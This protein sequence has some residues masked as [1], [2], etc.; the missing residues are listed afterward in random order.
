M[1]SLVLMG[2]P[3]ESPR[4]PLFCETDSK[5][6]WNALL[7]LMHR[8]KPVEVRRPSHFAL[9]CGPAGQIIKAACRSSL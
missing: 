6:Q 1:E 9:N 2:R 7:T 5:N 8:C 4:T 3:I